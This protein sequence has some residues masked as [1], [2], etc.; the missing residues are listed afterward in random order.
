MAALSNYLRNAL[1][2]AVLR[3]SSYSSPATVYLALYTSDPTVSHL[4]A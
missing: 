3:N 1:L 4:A 2:N